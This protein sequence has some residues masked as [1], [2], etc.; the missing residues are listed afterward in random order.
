MWCCAVPWGWVQIME[1]NFSG[2]TY[3]RREQEEGPHQ[4]IMEQYIREKM[5]MPKE[6]DDTATGQPRK[7]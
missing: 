1:S 6:G 2:L 7:R 5:G 4:K 3:M